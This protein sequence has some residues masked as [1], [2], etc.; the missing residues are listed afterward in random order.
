MIDL[1]ALSNADAQVEFVS[2]FQIVPCQVE[3]NL[4]LRGGGL[5]MDKDPSLEFEPIA[6]PTGQ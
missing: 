5:A 2:W 6:L 4:I 3:F 1:S